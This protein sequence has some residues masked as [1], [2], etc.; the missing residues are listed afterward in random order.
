MA[1][2]AEGFSQA[3]LSGDPSL[4]E[5]IRPRHRLDV[6]AITKEGGESRSIAG[7]RKVETKVTMGNRRGQSPA[8]T[9]EET[10]GAHCAACEDALTNGLT[11]V[12]MLSLVGLGIVLFLCASAMRT[13]HGYHASKARRLAIMAVHEFKILNKLKI[14]I[15]EHGTGSVRRVGAAWHI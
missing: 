15:G 1:E 4:S 13:C 9:S 7:S 8:K 11:S 10:K 6:I 2:G 12:M 14:L 3:G 5:S